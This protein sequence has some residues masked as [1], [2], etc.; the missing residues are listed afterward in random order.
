MDNSQ[1][2][3]VQNPVPSSPAMQ[4]PQAPGQ[5]AGVPGYPL[6]ADAAAANAPL[7]YAPVYSAP[8]PPPALP[9]RDARR[10][11]NRIGLAMALFIVIQ[12]VVVAVVY[13]LV[14]QMA[15][16]LMETGWFTWVVSYVPLYFVAFPVFLA[17]IA[18]MPT[19]S[20]ASSQPRRLT[21]LAF[22]RLLAASIAIYYIFNL[23]T[24]Y[25]SYLV[26]QARGT[27]IAGPAD[28]ILNSNPW[29]N[30]FFVCGVAPIME[31]II[32]RQLLYKRLAGFGGGVAVMVSALLFG[33][34][35]PNL[36]QFFY[37]FLLGILFGGLR[38]FTG[39]LWPCI[40]LH[41]VINFTGSGLSLILI[42]YFGHQAAT[43]WSVVLLAATVVGIVI[44]AHW[45]I[46]RRKSFVLE[47]GVYA[48]PRTSVI[49]LNVGMVLYIGFIVVMMA[50]TL[51][52]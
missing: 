7:A 33:L 2:S 13:T 36:Y 10:V 46:A 11:F 23:I 27:G 5:P 21:P 22:A 43:V 28:I 9:D 14:S 32:F 17:V 26:E 6:P 31:E 24:V 38:Y 51:L 1:D 41:M 12:Q 52:V 44:I 4:P 39:K 25:A 3:S 35:H 8:P 30:L 18:K 50:A 42:S 20:L 34:L 47:P 37:A 19:Y 40:L 48:K 29:V 16:Q 15:P 45:L 49:F